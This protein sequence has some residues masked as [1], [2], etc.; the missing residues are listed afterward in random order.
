MLEIKSVLEKFYGDY[1]NHTSKKLKMIDAY[2]LYILFTGVIQFAYCCLV[3]TFPFNS[4]LSGFISSVSCF[5]LGVCLRLQANP[6]NKTI[7]CK[8]SPERGFVDF[9]FAHVVLHLVVANFIG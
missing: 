5:I 8:I 7:F 2:L 4:F 1:V 6:E 3:G 9:I